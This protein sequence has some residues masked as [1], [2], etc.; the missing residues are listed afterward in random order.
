MTRDGGPQSGIKFHVLCT[1]CGRPSPVDLVIC[2][3]CGTSLAKRPGPADVHALQTMILPG[4]GDAIASAPPPELTVVDV[5]ALRDSSGDTDEMA[6][7]GHRDPFTQTAETSPPPPPSRAP[8][9]ATP[10]AGVVANRWSP[11]P[12][13]SD[14]HEDVFEHHSATSVRAARPLAAPLPRAPIS[15]GSSE[16]PTGFARAYGDHIDLPPGSVVHDAYEIDLK[17]GAGTMGEVYAARHL[18]LGKRVAIKVI[19]PRLSQDPA[20]VERFSRE[21]RALARIHHPGIVA[22]E[23]IGELPDHRAFFVMEHLTGEPL[24]ARL[25]RGPIPFD[26]ALDILDQIARA[27]DAAHRNGVIHRDLKPAN[28]F[29]VRIPDEARLVVK[30]LDFG[31]A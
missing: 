30:L 4:R 17:L 19:T 3:A 26:E 2:G 28:I 9:V 22:I 23:H 11:P 20:A 27:L 12:P 16:P 21:A 8:R 13:P 6:S 29:L 7:T 15:G 10:P 24:D 25:A 5:A 1:T 14:D 18:K 31:L